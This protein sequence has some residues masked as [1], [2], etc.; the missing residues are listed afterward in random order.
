[1]VGVGALSRRSVSPRPRSSYAR[2]VDAMHS[3]RTSAR[4]TTSTTSKGYE[5]SGRRTNCVATGAAL[6]KKTRASNATAFAP[7][8]DGACC[9]FLGLRGGCSTSCLLWRCWRV[10]SMLV[11]RA[12]CLICAQGPRVV[13]RFDRIR[14]DVSFYKPKPT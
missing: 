4:S 3:F 13:Y 9:V 6:A 14:R 7:V 1:M 10:P 11:Q 2:Q 5:P 8:F 12:V